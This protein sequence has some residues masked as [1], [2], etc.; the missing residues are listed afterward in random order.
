MD[1]PRESDAQGKTEKDKYHMLRLR[2][3]SKKQT[4]RLIDIEELVVARGEGRGRRRM[5]QREGYNVHFQ[6]ESEM[7]R[8]AQAVWRTGW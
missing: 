8:G 1:R 6:P 4:K 7:K 5:E 2:M 3:E